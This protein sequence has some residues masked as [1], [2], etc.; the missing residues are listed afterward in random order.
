MQLVPEDGGEGDSYPVPHF[1][2][3]DIGKHIPAR[4]L[5]NKALHRCLERVCGVTSSQDVAI[6]LP[7]SC[8]TRSGHLTAP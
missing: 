2:Y 5:L 8:H 4:L 3:H 6:L 7:F 1:R